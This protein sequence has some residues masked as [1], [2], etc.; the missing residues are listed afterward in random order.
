MFS[1]IENLGYKE[2]QSKYLQTLVSTG[3]MTVNEAR[4][5]L[6]LPQVEGGDK[7]IIAYTDI[8]QNTIN[9]KDNEQETTSEEENEEQ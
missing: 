9:N 6:E 8:N 5:V 3:I 1:N 4:K 7:L 2:K